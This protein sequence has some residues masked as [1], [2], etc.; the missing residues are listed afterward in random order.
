MYYLVYQ[1]TNNINGKIY[2][3]VHKTEDPDDGYMG[4]GKAIKAAIAKYGV[5]CFTKII[6]VQ[7]NSLEGMYALEAEI[8]N[9]E[10][11]S[12]PITYNLIEG[13]GISGANRT[14][15]NVYGM[16]GLPG[17]GGENL[18]PWSEQIRRMKDE[19]TWDAYKEAK[20]SRAREAFASGSRAP[21]FLGKTHSD[22]T[23][24]LIGEKNS[25]IQS[26]VGNSQYGSMWIHNIE[27][28]LNRKIK[29]S[30]PVPDGW[31]RGRKMKFE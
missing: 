25:N 11:V 27:L 15:A 26:G 28:K 22:E 16:N 21:S 31:I 10:F 17:Y 3:G 9:A 14:G 12:N 1:I 30:D 29:K 24:R 2:V 4:S 13:G 19:G 8:V 20:T 23:K 7:C 18:L 5:E 6:L